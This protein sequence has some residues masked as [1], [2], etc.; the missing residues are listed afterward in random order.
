VGIEMTEK[1]LQNY[2]Y[3]NPNLL[4]PGQTINEKSKEY[5]IR[6]KRI[7]LLFMVENT[8]Y[9][10]ELK[11]VPL[12]REHI[13]QIVEYYGLMKEYLND[14]NLRMMLVSPNI[15]SWK[16]VLL[17]ELGIQCIEFDLSTPIDKPQWN[18]SQIV[19]DRKKI[20]TILTAIQELPINSKYEKGIANSEGPPTR[21]DV[22]LVRR[23]M[24]ELLP[25]IANNFEE[26][27]PHP[28]G[29]TRAGSND[30]DYECIPEIYGTDMYTR[31]KAWFAFSF[32]DKKNDIPN[33]SIIFNSTGCDVTVDAEVQSSQLIVISK[34][35]KQSNKIDEIIANHGSLWFKAYLKLGHQP[36]AFHWIL[37][38]LIEPSKLYCNDILNLYK[39][40]CIN[41]QQLREKWINHIK[42]NNPFLSEKLKNDLE[43]NYSKS[44]SLALRFVDPITLNDGFWD[45]SFKEQNNV[46]LE[47]IV[48]LKP[49]IRLLCQRS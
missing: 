45:K 47:K 46:F 33:I 2:L 7:D 6:G 42:A 43:H 37:T 27:E 23:T 24:Q 15:P 38:T 28:F 34:I 22:G 29:I 20:N 9:I 32:G 16:S 18:G 30:F 44:V 11:A 3:E 26:F 17:E 4:F 41:Y 21:H 25:E 49:L 10:V 12:N 36:Q 1:E 31:G 8:R 5:Y 35:K 14:T 13:G 39:T 19:K 40:T 48:K